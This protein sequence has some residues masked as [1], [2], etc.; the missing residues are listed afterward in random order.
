MVH[1]NGTIN[2]FAPIYEIHV[3]VILVYAQRKL[4]ARMYR[5]SMMSHV[6]SESPCTIKTIYVQAVNDRMQAVNDSTCSVRAFAA[7]CCLHTLTKTHRL[8]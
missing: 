3:T 1:K 8:V 7:I 4:C 5:Y 6:L 2:L